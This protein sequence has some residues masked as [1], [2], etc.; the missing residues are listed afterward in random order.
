MDKFARIEH[1]IVMEAEDDPKSRTDPAWYPRSACVD[2]I[3]LALARACM[4]KFWVCQIVGEPGPIE[5]ANVEIL[6][7]TR[8]LRQRGLAFPREIPSKPDLLARYKRVTK[9]LE[10][11][12]NPY[13]QLNPDA[14]D[15]TDT[16]LGS[17]HMIASVFYEGEDVLPVD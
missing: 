14:H 7:R 12:E 10:E 1:D 13:D 3:A 16:V 2:D 4:V 11:Y 5:E 8:W 6:K 17:C 9:A 15:A